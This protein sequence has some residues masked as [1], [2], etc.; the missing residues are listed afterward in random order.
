MSTLTLSS[1][2]TLEKQPSSLLMT[3]M[4]TDHSRFWLPPAQALKLAQSLALLVR[5]LRLDQSTPLTLTPSSLKKSRALNQLLLK[6]HTSF[7]TLQIFMRSL[8]SLHPGPPL[9]SLPT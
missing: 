7:K 5:A 6:S 9:P 1:F 2:E 8:T 4:M 3:A